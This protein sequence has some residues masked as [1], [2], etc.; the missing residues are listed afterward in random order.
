MTYNT[1]LICIICF[2]PIIAVRKSVTSEEIFARLECIEYCHRTFHR[3]CLVPPNLCGDCMHSY[4]QDGGVCKRKDSQKTST[5]GYVETSTSR[6]LLDEA[7]QGEEDFLRD[8]FAT[9]NNKTEDRIF[10]RGKSNFDQYWDI[11]LIAVLSSI[12]LILIVAIISTLICL[13]RSQREQ[14]RDVPYQTFY[15]D[16]KGPNTVVGDRKLAY[17]AQMYHYQYQKQQMLANEKL[18]GFDQKNLSGNSTDEEVLDDDDDGTVYEYKGPAAI[19]GELEV[20]N[21]YFSESPNLP[22]YYDPNANHKNVVHH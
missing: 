1:L 9:S 4:F 22:G 18:N 19:E 3:S 15:G 6:E 7:S 10:L 16:G 13:C 8:Q 17:S 12:S 20:T 11:M 14:D 21:P 5:A 2:S